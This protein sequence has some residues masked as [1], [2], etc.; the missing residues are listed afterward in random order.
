[1]TQNFTLT[2]GLEHNAVAIIDGQI[3]HYFQV[4]TEDSITFQ[5]QITDNYIENNTAIQDHIAINPVTIT[6]RGYI[7]ELVFTEPVS[8]WNNITGFLGGQIA[9]SDIATTL[10]TKLTPLTALLPPVDNI[11]QA[12]KNT[13]QYVEASFDR[14]KKVYDQLF[15]SQ[16]ISHISQQED[17]A[18]KLKQLWQNRTLVE[19]IT[20]YGYYE[21]MAIQSISLTQGNTTTQSDLSVTL[22]QINFATTQTTKPDTNVM[23]AYN[24]YARTQEANHGKA[25]GVNDDSFIGNLIYKHTGIEPARYRG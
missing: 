3:G 7:G 18:E 21:N 23:S 22:K 24:A 13:V 4:A 2:G 8:F 11:T 17:T 9:K 5:S 6:M 20:P 25:Q 12:A 15:N 10:T 16:N 1:M 14:Y 19:V